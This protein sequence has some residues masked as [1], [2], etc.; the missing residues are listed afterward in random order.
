MRST[1]YNEGH[2]T[3]ID[4]GGFIKPRIDNQFLRS[5]AIFYGFKHHN[6]KNETA[7]GFITEQ[8]VTPSRQTQYNANDFQ[9]RQTL[10]NISL[11][12]NCMLGEK[13]SLEIQ[14]RQE[15][16]RKHERDYLFHPDTISLPS[17]MDALLAT[18]D[19]G[20]SYVSDYRE[21]TNTP[22]L[23]LTWKKH[24][25]GKYQK[26]EYL[27]WNLRVT[28]IINSEHL[29]Y[30]RANRVQD[31]KRTSCEFIPRFTFKILPTKK[32]G[33]QLQLQLM[34]EQSA[35]SMFDLLDYRDD[36]TPQVVTLG[37]PHLKG[38]AS[39]YFGIN[40]TDKESKHKGKVYNLKGDFCYFHRQVAQSV[41]FNP[42]NSQYT[43]Q[44]QNV[45]GAYKASARFD[46]TR[47][48]DKRQRWSWQA[49]A[50]AAYHH[51]IDHVMQTGMEESTP[52]AVNTLTLRPALWLQ[53]QQEG[54]SAR[55]TG[56]ISWRHSEGRMRNFETLNAIDYR[57]GLSARYTLPRIKTTLSVDGNMYSRRGYGS[58]ELNTDDFVLNASILQPFLKGKLIARIE[59][60][61]LLHQLSSTQYE[62]NAQGRTETWYRSLP[63]YVMAHLVFHFSKNPKKR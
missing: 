30:T 43:Y 58:A 36:A 39:T 29:L 20:N 31:K 3:T 21:C 56:D 11:L 54:F 33:E 57:Y 35:P 28:S 50:D 61:D 63:H 60:F 59:A 17:Q 14:D 32:A 41:T 9:N 51:S 22:S 48:L 42:D 55:A 6:D 37:N 1:N 24:I 52:N 15:Y 7:R 26:L 34:Y 2:A 16:S 5:L 12:W 27:S 10:G 38:A 53:Y 45:S 19:P 46:F 25:S 18:T 40:F 49:M 4:V 44:P 8:F 23:S 13:L 62:V 47:F